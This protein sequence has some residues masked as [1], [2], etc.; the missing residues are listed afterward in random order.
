MVVPS[1]A[2]MT[3]RERHGGGGSSV[4]WVG[5]ERDASGTAARVAR[6]LRCGRQHKPL[7]QGEADLPSLKG[8]LRR[9]ALEMRW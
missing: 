4:G 8:R 7:G 3:K 2:G 5:G 1:G 9:S 6:S